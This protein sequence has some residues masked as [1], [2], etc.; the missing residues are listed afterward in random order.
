V[1]NAKVCYRI[2]EP[3]PEKWEPVFRRDQA[4]TKGLDHDTILFRIMI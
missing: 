2:A 4:Q 3:D 1:P